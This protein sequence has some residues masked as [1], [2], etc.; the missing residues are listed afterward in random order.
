[1]TGV[2]TIFQFAVQ[3]MVSLLENF[4]PL[5]QSFYLAILN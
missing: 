3:D 5:E 2:A 1:M 4:L